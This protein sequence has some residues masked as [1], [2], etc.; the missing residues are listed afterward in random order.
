MP[1]KLPRFRL[2]KF[3][4][5]TSSSNLDRA[6]RIRSNKVWKARISRTQ[7]ML[8]GYAGKNRPINIFRNV[9]TVQEGRLPFNSE[10]FYCL[11]Y[12]ENF[13]ITANG[14]TGITTGTYTYNLT[15]PYDPRIQLLGGQP[16]QYDQ[17]SYMYERYWVRKCEVW[18]TFSNPKYS[19]MYCGVR[20]RGST[21][22]VEVYNKTIDECREM[23]LTKSKPINAN[24]EGRTK[25]KFTVIPWQILGITKGQYNNLEY[26]GT[27]NAV[28]SVNVILEPYAAHTVSGQEDATIRCYVYI[29]YY[30]QMTNKQTV[31]DA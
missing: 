27:V 16:L 20:V 26:S 7:T 6:R 4:P 9:A 1:A 31:L 13:A 25:F 14:T 8:S 29:K 21:N 15:G 2:K 12:S 22:P 17:I 19:G 5:T 3:K 30:I 18:V 11:P 23:D 10:G 28:P 24:G